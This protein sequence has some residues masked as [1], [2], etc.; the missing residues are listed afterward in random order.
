M[1][2][3]I[4]ILILL[5]I[6]I[7]IKT[8]EAQEKTILK[9]TVNLNDGYIECYNFPGIS[10]DGNHIINVHSDY[11]CCIS[12]EFLVELRDVKT[13]GIKTDVLIYPSEVDDEHFTKEELKMKVK[14][15]NQMLKDHDFQSMPLVNL[16]TYE[17]LHQKKHLYNLNMIV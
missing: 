11:S 15:I 10:K 13:N 3:Y 9:P 6:T 14:L 4:P 1:K 2:T 5:I 12:T 8:L 17:K 16:Y 7:N